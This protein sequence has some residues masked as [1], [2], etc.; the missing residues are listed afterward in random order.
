MRPINEIIKDLED[1]EE[2]TLPS[3][4]A[5]ETVMYLELLHDLMCDTAYYFNRYMENQKDTN[6]N[7]Q[8]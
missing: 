6:K 2:K 1:H 7:V 8:S 3:K 4:L 5:Y